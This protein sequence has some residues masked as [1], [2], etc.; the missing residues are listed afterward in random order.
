M[1]DEKG[2]TGKISEFP[3]DQEVEDTL[4]KDLDEVRIYNEGL[5]DSSTDGMALTDELGCIKKVNKSFAR[6]LGYE[7]NELVGKYWAELNPLEDEV[8]FTTYGEKVTGSKYL[9]TAYKTLEGF[10]NREGG[11][12]GEFYFKRRDGKL[13]PVWNTIYWIDDCKGYGYSDSV[14]IIRDITEKKIA[15]KEL[16]QAYNELREAKEYLENII[17]TSADAIIITDPKCR[18]TKGNNAL[19]E[20]TGFTPEE[21]VGKHVSQLHA[22]FDDPKIHRSRMKIIDT[23]F[24]TGRVIGMESLWKS[25]NGELI[26]VEINSSLLRDKQTIIGIV[27]CVRDIRERKRIE[28]MEIKNAFLSNISHEFRTPLTLS[29][30]PLEGLL[31]KKGKVAGKEAQEKIELALKNNRQLL[32]LINQ[33]LDFSRLEST[34]G[35]VNYYRKDINQFLSSLVDAFTFLAQKKDIRLNFIQN[36]DTPP[37]YFDPGKMGKVFFNIIGNAFKFTPRGGSI[38]IEVKQDNEEKE[39]NFLAISIGD[40][41]IGI[42]DEDLPSVFERF[43]QAESTSSIRH[44]GTG[45]GLSL[46]K[47]LIELQGGRIEVDSEYGQGSTFTIYIPTGKAHIKDHSQIKENGEEIILTEKEIEFSDLY[48]DE[49][50]TQEKKPTGERP[51][52]LFVDDNPAVRKYVADILSKQYDVITAEDGLAGL[53]QIKR[54]IPDIIISDIMMPGMDGYEFCKTVKSNPKLQ[55]IPLI[56][57]TAKA[58]TEFK[59]ESLEEGADDYIVKPFNSQELMA[60]V[61]SM[62][63]IQ[64]LVRENALKEQKVAELTEVLGEKSQYHDLVGKSEVM[65]EVYRFLERIKGSVSPVL[66]NGETGTGKELVAHAIHRNSKR[67]NRPFIILNCTAISKNLMESELFGH[68]KGAFTGAVANKKGIFESADGGTLFL[69][70]IGEIGV[71]TQSKLLRVLEEGT[72]R[73]VGGSRE[74]KADVRIITATNRD[75][76]KMIAKG[77]FRED[78]YYRINVINIS[79]PPLRKKKEDISLL[80]EHFIKSLEAGEGRQRKFSEKALTKLE[81]YNYPGNVRELKNIVERTLAI[82]QKDSICIKDLALELK[83][84]DGQQSPL[85]PG[86]QEQTLKDVKKHAEREAII[87]ALKQAHGNKVKAAQLL[88]ISRPTLYTKIEEYQIE[89]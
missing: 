24:R 26:S 41:G 50:R 37:T 79:L 83:A 8:C 49:V 45:I 36:E 35:D 65:Q 10:Y 3:K 63:R 6:L 38:T 44:Q 62:L 55:H 11:G 72:F 33:L 14:T 78:L 16:K 86:E 17:V 85:T 21:L 46:A 5:F 61:K 19:T 47:E 59:I 39:N 9:E 31:Q 89:C 12:S 42:K 34:D 28:K 77:H 48:G 25:K 52:I 51:L 56:F 80:V 67:K 71:D 73:P 58:D 82:C 88:H 43:Q 81:Q 23:L 64:E 7:M 1:N 53:K 60:R 27:A 76:R 4:G 84:K 70:E 32:K 68:V 87:K 22:H 74:K 29:I 30:G 20:L 75:L 2:K 18:I 69:D 66:I 15:E 40:T 54:Y 13:I 57:L